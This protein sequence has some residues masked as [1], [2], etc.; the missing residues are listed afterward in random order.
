MK[1]VSKDTINIVVTSARDR[2]AFSVGETSS[3]FTDALSCRFKVVLEYARL[4][5]SDNTVKPTCFRDFFKTVSE[6]FDS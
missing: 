3:L 6:D 4:V 5:T 2:H 1:L